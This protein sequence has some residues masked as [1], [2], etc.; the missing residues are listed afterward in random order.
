M[1][2][3]LP[4]FASVPFCNIDVVRDLE[5]MNAGPTVVPYNPAD[6]VSIAPCAGSA[7][8]DDRGLDKYSSYMWVEPCASGPSPA[9]SILQ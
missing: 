1:R 8:G 3:G 7:W 6:R 9:R 5:A 2:H 4:V